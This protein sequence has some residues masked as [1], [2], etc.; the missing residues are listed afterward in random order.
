MAKGQG[1]RGGII[2]DL[3]TMPTPETGFQGELNCSAEEAEV[4]DK[5]AV[6]GTEIGRAHV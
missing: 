1:E 5:V 6:S 3:S 4:G 2:R